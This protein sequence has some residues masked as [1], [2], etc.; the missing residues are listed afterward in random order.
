M[1]S[2]PE[3]KGKGALIRRYATC[4][5]RPG[6]GK[7]KPKTHAVAIYHFSAQIIGRSAGRSSVAASAY[8][9]GVSLTD[10]RTGQVHDFTR[11]RGVDFSAV[12]AP[13]D[14]PAWAL[15]RATLWNKVE[16]IEKRKDAQVCREFNIALPVE[17]THDQKIEVA[18]EWADREMVAKGMVVQF[19]AHDL[20]SHNPHVHLMVTMRRIEGDGFGQKAREW[21]DK[22]QLE[23]WR[24]SWE[25]YA[26]AALKRAG[27]AERV[28]HR[29]LEAQGIDHV[30]TTHL[31]PHASAV[32]R[33]TGQLSR[34]RTDWLDASREV[35]RQRAQETARAK[36]KDATAASQIQALD[37]AI[38]VEKKTLQELTSPDRP[39]HELAAE[40]K[41]VKDVLPDFR[42]AVEQDPRVLQTAAALKAV[43]LKQARLQAWAKS[44]QEK[45][46]QAAVMHQ[47]ALAK[48]PTAGGR[49]PVNAEFARTRTARD[50]WKEKHPL[51]S[52]LHD[53]GVWAAQSLTDQNKVLGD[54]SRAAQAERLHKRAKF[55][56]QAHE[57]ASKLAQK[58]AAWAAQVLQETK[59]QVRQELSTQHP[60]Q[61][62]LYHQLKQAFVQASAREQRER[63]DQQA[64]R[65]P[66]I[67]EALIGEAIRVAGASPNS[68]L[69]QAERA[70][71]RDRVE[72]MYRSGLVHEYSAEG[73]A[74][75]AREQSLFLVH[76]ALEDCLIAGDEAA[77]LG[78]A[79]PD[80]DR[81]ITGRDVP[82]DVADEVRS[83][84][85]RAQSLDT[86]LAQAAKIIA[87]GAAGAQALEALAS[88]RGNEK[89]IKLAKA[90]EEKRQEAQKEQAA[91]RARSATP[92]AKPKR[93]GEPRI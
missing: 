81:V 8:R 52:W 34:K 91:A 6:R 41:H 65:A 63:V 59:A 51:R 28:D 27:R 20:A 13:V 15:D 46:K 66:L 11:K 53:K 38:A 77:S 55:F 69:A 82:R 42:V 44:G 54:L 29:T 70:W 76:T 87:G 16:A 56:Q 92:E 2:C 90:I 30:P 1:Y 50:A 64:V 68:P 80:I 60:G 62:N 12:L 37:E 3:P 18:R 49:E 26:N 72:R 10:E 36:I 85:A 71:L 61:V 9:A 93:P 84:F 88:A 89:L 58:A 67:A 5:P 23:A 78:L 31:G 43:Q 14:S 74:L 75:R 24:V 48:L 7:A 73:R 79:R 25:E 83:G 86:G 4:A 19:D 33:R 32:E 45:E 39:V 22:A 21:N 35:M 47:A 40:L 17:L 57:L